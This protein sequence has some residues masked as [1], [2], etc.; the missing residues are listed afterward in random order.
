MVIVGAVGLLY[1][2]L[3]VCDWRG[4]ARHGRLAQVQYSADR[5]P[6]LIVVHSPKPPRP[7]ELRG[8]GG[9]GVGCVKNR[10]KTGVF[11]D[12]V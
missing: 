11:N 1:C 4:R 5:V 2:G 3:E 8:G 6:H 10:Y 9:L 7:V 12:A